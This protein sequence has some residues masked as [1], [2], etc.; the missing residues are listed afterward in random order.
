MNIAARLRRHLP[1]GAALLLV[2]FSNAPLAADS[3]VY[4]TKFACGTVTG[5]LPTVTDPTPPAAQ[6]IYRQVEPGS[7]ATV[8]NILHA[9][10]TP[11]NT[12]QLASVHI[13][14]V[15]EGLG[16]TSLDRGFL[17][18]TTRKI[19][20][21]EITQQLAQAFPSFT[22]DGRFVEGYLHVRV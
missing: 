5:T 10:Y 22:A 4:S 2:I 8:L 6:T 19:G 3:S 18:F 9:P 14:I 12:V 17:P 21:P 7:Y 15:V 13:S 16:E 1:A 20:C 11:P